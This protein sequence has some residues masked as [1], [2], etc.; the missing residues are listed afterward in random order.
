MP[1]YEFVEGTSKKF[2]EIAVAGKAVTTKWGRLG[3]PGS[4]KTKAFASP[5]AAQKEHDKLVAEKT[6]KGYAAVGGKPAKAKAAKAAAPV[7]EEPRNA[8]L[9]KA[10]RD[11]PDDDGAYGVYGD[12]LAQQ[13][14]PRG[15]LATA[16]LAR[17]TAV[18]KKLL[19]KHAALWGELAGLEDVVTNVIWKG[20]FIERAR[21]A[22]TFERSTMHGGEKS[23]IDVADVVGKLLAGP[24]RFLRELVVGI[25]DYEGNGYRDVVKAIAAHKSVPTLRSLYFGDFH[26]EETELNWS[27]IGEITE[28]GKACPNLQRL[29]LR[30]G[31]MKL[32]KL[33]FPNL[34]GLTIFSGGL[35]PASSKAIADAKWPK[36]E[37]LDLMFGRKSHGALATA[38]PL[39][40]LFDARSVPRL[41]ALGIKNFEFHAELVPMLLRSKLLRQLET[42]DLSLGTMGDAE[43]ALLLAGKAQLAHLKSLDVSENF[44]TAAGLKTLKQIGIPIETK[45]GNGSAWNSNKLG[46]RDDED[47]E[48]PSDRYASIY[49]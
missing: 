6:K 29:K 35:D 38:K 17:N 41:T 46:Q 18:A 43:A 14:H 49:E 12:W 40:A 5:A 33:D 8:A 23:T 7:V 10:I 48:D 39:Q 42:L 47:P 30:S 28:L 16:Q 19:A 11:D 2:W 26:S 37:K 1:R 22:N 20:G 24:G 13:G 9:E 36:L 15:E 4:E 45:S 21:V 44:F 3:T 32:G 27:A 25:V 31:G 34:V